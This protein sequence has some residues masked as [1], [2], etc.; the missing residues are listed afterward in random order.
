MQNAFSII[1]YVEFSYPLSSVACKNNWH[2]N[3]I[4]LETI[5]LLGVTNN[6]PDIRSDV[7]RVTSYTN[8]FLKINSTR[9]GNLIYRQ[10]ISNLK[11]STITCTFVEL[12]DIPA[13]LRLLR[14]FH[15]CAC[16]I[17]CFTRWEEF[18][19][20]YYGTVHAKMENANSADPWGSPPCEWPESV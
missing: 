19:I 18:S 12:E 6:F 16:R 1:L 15:F 9:L 2:K 13:G 20:G 3:D 14:A 11:R 17:I 4:P 8:S 10:N 5:I 7:K